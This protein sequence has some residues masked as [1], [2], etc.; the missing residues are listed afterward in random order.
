MCASRSARG[1]GGRSAREATHPVQ[2]AGPRRIPG[3]ESRIPGVR[4]TVTTV[5]EE[6]LP[7]PDPE[8]VCERLS[9][10]PYRLW[11]DSA[12]VTSRLG[13]F[14]FVTADPELVVRGRDRAVE[15]VDRRGES[16]HHE[17]D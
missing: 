8:Q 5:I 14:S 2:Q 17:G 4:E 1:R 12:T 15:I 11:L 13:Q 10:L 6:L 9:G 7:V 3:P 16:R